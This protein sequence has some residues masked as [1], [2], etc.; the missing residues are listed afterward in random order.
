MGPTQELVDDIYRERVLRARRT[1][2][3][4]KILAGAELFEF[5]C[6]FACA[7]IRREN[8]GADEAR[9]QALLRDRLVLARRLGA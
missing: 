5:A 7:G 4:Q 3:E 6:R 8:P 9:V 1:P 2:I